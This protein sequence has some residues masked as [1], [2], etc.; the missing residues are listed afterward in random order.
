MALLTFSINK[1]VWHIPYYYTSFCQF[2]LPAQINQYKPSNTD[3]IYCFEPLT[4]F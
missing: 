3:A 2:K 4:N 1:V